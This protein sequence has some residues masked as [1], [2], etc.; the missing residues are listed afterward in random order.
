[1][2]ECL[3]HPHYACPC[4]EE[5]FKALIE[6]AKKLLTFEFY[7]RFPDSNPYTTEKLEEAKDELEKAIAQAVAKA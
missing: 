5:A 4:R 6:K 2:K 1:M 7:D 3:S